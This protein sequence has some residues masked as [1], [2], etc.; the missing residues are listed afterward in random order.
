MILVG[1]FFYVKPW[2]VSFCLELFIKSITSYEDKSFNSKKYSHAVTKIIT[3][4]KDS[5]PIF[6]RIANDSA[7]FN[8]I[9]EYE[10]TIDTKFGETSVQIDGD[11][12]M[13]LVRL[14]HELN[15]ELDQKS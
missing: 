6:K 8:L 4:Y 3:D 13:K 10:K 9:L 5:I 15:N 1:L 7:L 12:Q 14:I 2:I 11:D